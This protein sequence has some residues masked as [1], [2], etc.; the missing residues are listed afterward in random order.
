MRLHCRSSVVLASL[1]IGLAVPRVGAQIAGRQ[2]SPISAE[3]LMETVQ[4]LA[5]PQFDGRRTA[6]PGN[7]EARRWIL[8]RVGQ[9]G[10]APVGDRFE[11]PFTFTRPSTAAG[12]SASTASGRSDSVAIGG[13]NVA[14]LCRGSGSV[15]KG[16]IVISA[17][18][19]HLGVRDG[20]MYPGADDNASGVAVWLELARHCRQSPWTHDVMFV[21][22]DAEELG[23]QGAR[24]F[25]ASPPI[26]KKLLALNVNLDMVSRSAKREVYI[27]G[28]YH[29]PALKTVLDPIASR[30]PISVLFGH[31]KPTTIAGGVDDWTMQSDHGPFH[32]AGIPFVYFGVED[33][34][35]YHKPTDTADKIDQ[36]FFGQVATTVRDAVTALDR[37]LPFP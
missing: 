24:A 1:A 10:L 9:L 20:T 7:A 2:S 30:A 36:V 4:T 6:T 8:E 13:V 31:D 22:F 29:R 28:T 3:A 23:L 34:A 27:A 18:Y 11:I 17:H 15:D 12:P 35:D 19:D 32:A 33:H 37:A 21:A 25:V 5:S 26:P 14:A 16:V